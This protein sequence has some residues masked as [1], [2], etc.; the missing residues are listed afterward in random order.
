MGVAIITHP[1]DNQLFA[2]Y[3]YNVYG[4]DS[5]VEESEFSNSVEFVCHDWNHFCLALK[6]E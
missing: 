1:K 4:F 3:K 5:I 6:K 2:M